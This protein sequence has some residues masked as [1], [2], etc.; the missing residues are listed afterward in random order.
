MLRLILVDLLTGWRI[1]PA[2]V[3]ILDT[4][5]NEEK[6]NKIITERL[7]WLRKEAAVTPPY[8]TEKIDTLQ[9]VDK[10]FLKKNT[11]FK[12]SKAKFI[13][14]KTGG[15]TG[16]PFVYRASVECQGFLWAS[17][18]RSWIETGYR[19][20]QKIAFLA[21]SSVLGSSLKKNIFYKLMNI[22]PFS[23]FGLN[24]ETM[25]EAIRE[26]KRKNIKYLYGYSNAIYHLA[27]FCEEKKVSLKLSGVICTAEQLS[28][29]SRDF[30]QSVFGGIV[31]RQYGVNDGGLSS[32]ECT[33]RNG[34]HVVANRSIVEEENGCLVSTDLVNRSQLFVRYRV[35][36]RGK[37]SNS[38]CPCGVIYPRI[39]ELLGRENDIVYDNKGNAFHSEYFTHFFRS[40]QHIEQWQ[41]IAEN[42][43]VHINIH[44]SYN[45]S[46]ENLKI[47]LTKHLE[48]SSSFSDTKIEFNKD[49][50]LLSNGKLRFVI[51]K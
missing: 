33:H 40:Y 7:T 41:V 4:E 48:S 1:R 6:L 19:P 49:F 10:S 42:G 5:K 29:G 36:D 8:L 34:F 26:I 15:S 50:E 12:T 35:G 11:Y 13:E 14:K 18:I 21:G 2:L 45:E 30:I 9:P 3:E 38:R 16:E 51:Q 47:E 32:F 25:S 31:L 46:L 17:I 39:T 28:D 24:D 44:A 27:K 23:S 43:K 20:G 22:T 37:I